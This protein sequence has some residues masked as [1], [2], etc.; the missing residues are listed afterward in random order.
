MPTSAT[1]PA[2][3]HIGISLGNLDRFVDGLGEFSRQLGLTL[4][5]RAPALREQH[6]VA[7][8]FH[9]V[10]ALHGCF[11]T[12]VGYLAVQRS[13]EWWHR[14][15]LHFGLW[16]TLN[17]L[18]RYP[19]PQGTERHLSTVHDLNFLYVK[20]GYSRWRDQRR[21]RRLLAGNDAVVTISD[22]VGA[23]VRLHGGW[24]GPMQ[25]IYNGVRDLRAEPQSPVEGLQPQ[26][27]LFHISRMAPSKNVESLLAMMALWP[28]QTL[29]LAG[30]SAERNAELLAWV[31]TRQL[32]NVRIIT[33]PDEAQKT[34]LYAHCAAFLFPSLTEGFGLPPI[35]AMHFG[36]PVVLARRTCLPEIGGDA[37]L[38]FDD[39]E[40]VGM[41]QVVEQALADGARPGRAEQV[42]A[43][44]ARFSWERAADAYVALYLRLL[45]PSTAAPNAGAERPS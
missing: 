19:P 33:L 44:A 34:W 43:H 28:E 25:T 12:E 45:Q 16:H 6:G 14:Q 35:E 15:P 4:A 42:R 37:A 26:G 18:N 21:L 41:R 38:Y 24:R 8:H 2:I 27:F 36:K 3:R 5:A 13:Q 7:L 10:P 9:T 31:D 40:P 1:A 29:V 22:H 32:R 30:P 17:Q 23:D 11:G 20:H 39:F